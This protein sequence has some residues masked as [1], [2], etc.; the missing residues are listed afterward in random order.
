MDN[1]GFRDELNLYS[2]RWEFFTVILL[3]S[4][5]GQIVTQVTLV[6]KKPHYSNLIQVRISILWNTGNNCAKDCQ[7]LPTAKAD[8]F[9]SCHFEWHKNIFISLMNDIKFKISFISFA[10]PPSF[11][12][13][14]TTCHETQKTKTP[15]TANIRQC[16]FQ[17]LHCD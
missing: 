3:V 2:H 5:K 4:K 13:T 9:F 17:L 1:L 11:P 8:I 10:N 14:E 16:F 12:W 7:G 15:S 6:P